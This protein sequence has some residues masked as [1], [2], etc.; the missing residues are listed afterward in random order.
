MR[1]MPAAQGLPDQNQADV[2]R[3]YEALFCQVR[4]THKFGSGWPDLAVTIP[5]RRGRILDLVEVKMTSAEARPS[6]VTFQRDFYPF[7]IVRTQ[8]DVTAHVER[9]QGR[10]K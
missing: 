2:I 4:D 7:T 10:F 9:V 3:W 5:T 1:R 8:E 6:Q